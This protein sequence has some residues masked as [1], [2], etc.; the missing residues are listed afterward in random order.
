VTEFVIVVRI[1]KM[2]NEF[3]EPVAALELTHLY[4]VEENLTH[5]AAK[6]PQSTHGDNVNRLTGNTLQN[7][8]NTMI[9]LHTKY[10]D[11]RVTINKVQL[12]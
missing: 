11:I 6:T 3:Q 8:I 5:Y 4:S 10:N 1:L 9:F 12:N 7:I 2:I